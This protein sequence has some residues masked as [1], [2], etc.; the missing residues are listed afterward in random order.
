MCAQSQEGLQGRND[1]RGKEWGRKSGGRLPR[2]RE[3][4]TK[5]TPP[6]NPFCTTTSV[7]PHPPPK[8]YLLFPVTADGCLQ[9]LVFV[10][11]G[12]AA[13]GDSVGGLLCL[14]V[15][16]RTEDVVKEPEDG[17][18]AH[19]GGQLVSLGACVQ[20]TSTSA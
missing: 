14:L 4:R 8:K 17:V 3:K 16:F 5:K 6:A 10:F 7:P 11:V 12:A 1:T 2:K 20:N 19:P 9:I 18:E 13:C 15:F